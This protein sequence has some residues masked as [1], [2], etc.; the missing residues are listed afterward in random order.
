MSSR[1]VE[2]VVNGAGRGMLVVGDV[3]W[4]DVAVEVAMIAAQEKVPTLKAY[5]ESSPH[6]HLQI[7]TDR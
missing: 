1:G 4:V 6:H 2:E 5:F 3:I 7:V